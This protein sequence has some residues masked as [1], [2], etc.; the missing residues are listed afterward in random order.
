MVSLETMTWKPQSKTLKL[1]G[2][3]KDRNVTILVDFG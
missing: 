3:I 2:V 1:K